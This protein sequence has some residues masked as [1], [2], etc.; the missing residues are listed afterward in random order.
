MAPGRSD[1]N[2][3]TTLGILSHGDEFLLDSAKGPLLQNLSSKVRLFTRYPH[4]RI[5]V[6]R[7]ASVQRQPKHEANI[8][9][10]STEYLLPDCPTFRFVS[11]FTINTGRSSQ[12]KILRCFHVTMN[13]SK[14]GLVT[15]PFTRYSFTYVKV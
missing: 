11:V 14:E 1:R 15:F 6:I 2:F 10:A 4:E 13:V 8:R 9:P 5:H 7:I 3:E 12:Q